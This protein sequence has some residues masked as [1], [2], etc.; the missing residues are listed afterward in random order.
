VV[1]EGKAINMSDMWR[2]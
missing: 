2:P 1:K